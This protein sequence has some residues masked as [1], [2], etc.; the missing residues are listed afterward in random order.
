MRSARLAL[1]AA[2][3]AVLV[4]PAAGRGVRADASWIAGPDAVGDNTYI[5]AIDSPQPNVSVVIGRPLRVSGWVADSTAQGWAG[6]DEVRVY[7]GLMN[8][9]GRLLGRASIAQSRPDVAATTG[10][11]A[12]V[13]SGFAADVSTAGLAEGP[14]LLSVYAHTP[15][16]GWWYRQV[17]VGLVAQLYVSDPIN[18]ITWPVNGQVVSLGQSWQIAGYALDRNAQYGTGIDRVLVY[19]DGDSER[20]TRLGE[21]TRGVTGTTPAAFGRQ[22]AAA[23]YRLTFDHPSSRLRSGPHDLSIYA[24]SAVSGRTTLSDVTF[25]ATD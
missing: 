24:H 19:L 4:A 10:V 12:F 21:A 11:P 16:K 25:Q 15:A 3:L 8:A 5:G 7:V 20:G 9:D 23:G 6:I 2:V 14:T 22:F 17:S 18:V 13:A 1:A